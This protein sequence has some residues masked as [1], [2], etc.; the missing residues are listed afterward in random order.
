MWRRSSPANTAMLNASPATVAAAAPCIPKRGINAIC[1]SE[2]QDDRP[3][4]KKEARRRRSGCEQTTGQQ[5]TAR[6]PTVRGPV[7]RI[8][9]RQPGNQHGLQ[10]LSDVGQAFVGP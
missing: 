1:R 9:A 2:Q 5:P 8:V 10:H 7:G 6:Q 4:A 3:F